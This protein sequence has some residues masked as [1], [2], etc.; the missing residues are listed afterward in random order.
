VH[1]SISAQ[2]QAEQTTLCRTAL[3]IDHPGAL[4]GGA[5]QEKRLSKPFEIVGEGSAFAEQGAVLKGGA[6]AGVAWGYGD[7]ELFHGGD[8]IVSDEMPTP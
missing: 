5:G 4:Q 3:V 2:D 1:H 8:L 6:R 7:D